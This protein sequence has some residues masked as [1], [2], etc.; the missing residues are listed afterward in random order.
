[1]NKI[2]LVISYTTNQPILATINKIEAQKWMKDNSDPYNLFKDFFIKEVC[3][4]KNRLLRNDIW[5][6]YNNLGAIIDILPN[7]LKLKHYIDKENI[8][9]VFYVK[10]VK[11]IN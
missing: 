5:I 2:F 3:N 10:N 7:E 8:N 1:M 4:N 11:L 9:N 6:L